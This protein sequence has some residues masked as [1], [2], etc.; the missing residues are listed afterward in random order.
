MPAPYRPIGVG[1]RPSGKAATFMKTAEETVEFGKVI[2]Q[3]TA[4]GRKCET[5]FTQ[6]GNT[7]VQVQK[8]K[9]A[10]GPDVKIT[11]VFED[12]G[13][14]VTMETGDVVCKQYFTRQ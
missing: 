14:N 12:N 4:D 10:G 13:I 5:T 2:D 3:E 6:D 11:R 1:V 7:W 8:N 9:K